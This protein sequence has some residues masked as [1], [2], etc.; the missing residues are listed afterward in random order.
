MKDS[1]KW[2]R[3]SHLFMAVL[4]LSVGLNSGVA[5]ESPDPG[6]PEQLQGRKSYW[7]QSQPFMSKSRISAKLAR[8]HSVQELLRNLYIVWIDRLLVEPGFYD[9]FILKACF[10]GTSVVWKDLSVDPTGDQSNRVAEVLLDARV[11]PQ[12]VVRV[13]LYRQKEP[14]T[15]RLLVVLQ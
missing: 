13:R 2:T 3:R 11:F 9:D 12:M 8:P 6:S 10:N 1:T 4:V 15:N 7:I 5:A 14:A